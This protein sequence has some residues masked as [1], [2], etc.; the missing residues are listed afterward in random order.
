M[1]HAEED[2]CHYIYFSSAGFPYD[3]HSRAECGGARA[4]EPQADYSQE[5]IDAAMEQWRADVDEELKKQL[6][7]LDLSQM[8]NIAQQLSPSGQELLQSKSITQIIGEIASGSMTMDAGG[9]L[10]F[11]GKLFIREAGY[12][13]PSV[14]KAIVLTILAACLCP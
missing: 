9:L 10:D 1:R 13:W 5:E 6:N 2:I 3:G 4:E 12:V 7:N 11:M 14:L 8:E